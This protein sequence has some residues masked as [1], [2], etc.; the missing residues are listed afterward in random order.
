M[1][2]ALKFSSSKQTVFLSLQK[3]EENAEISISDHGC[4]IFPEEL[5]FIFDRFYKSDNDKNRNGTGL[6][7]PIAR[8][9]ANRHNIEIKVSS[10]YKEGTTFE[11]LFSNNSYKN[12]FLEREM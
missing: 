1:D 4:G 6:G 9:I 8:Q 2:N 7:L 3:R 11:L 12:I 10:C 5:P